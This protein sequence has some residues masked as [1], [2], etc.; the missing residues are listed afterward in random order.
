MVSTGA[1]PNAS[2]CCGDVSAWSAVTVAT[3]YTDPLVFH[4]TVI[5]IVALAFTAR[6]PMEHVTSGEVNVQP[7]E[8]DLKVAPAG[9]VSVSSYS[10]GG[11]RTAVRYGNRVR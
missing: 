3:S 2:V 1:V 11:E 10:R 8:A 9:R 6:F 5:V 7:V 4:V